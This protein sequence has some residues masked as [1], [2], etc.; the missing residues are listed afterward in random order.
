M[1]YS[2]FIFK[3]F[4]RKINLFLI[5]L[6]YTFYHNKVIINNTIWFYQLTTS[7]HL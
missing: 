6:N 3:K 5:F 1:N 7:K 2:L 4:V